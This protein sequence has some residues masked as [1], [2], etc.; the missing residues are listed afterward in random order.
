ME[1]TKRKTSSGRSLRKVYIIMKRVLK[2]RSME[3]RINKKE[4]GTEAEGI[5]WEEAR[6]IVTVEEMGDK[7]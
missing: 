5:K 1:T 6:T 4:Y 3:K 7:Y 2:A